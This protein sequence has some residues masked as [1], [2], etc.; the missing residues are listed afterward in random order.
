MDW[1]V[2]S[3]LSSIITVFLFIIYMI[4]RFWAIKNKQKINNDH[5][6]ILG[7][8]EYNKIADFVNP[9]RFC[10]LGEIELNKF[11]SDM[12]IRRFNIYKI[13]YIKGSYLKWEKEN[14]KP[15]YE[16]KGLNVGEEIYIKMRLPCGGP[17]EYLIEY[18]RDDYV[19]VSFIPAYNQFENYVLKHCYKS[20]MSFLGHIYYFFQ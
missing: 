1:D 8:D 6:E 18:I 12:Y 2:I 5:F 10:D 13:K 19:K 9:E 4:G 17:S 20:K 14:K 15:I 16:Y 11:S 7:A 3:E